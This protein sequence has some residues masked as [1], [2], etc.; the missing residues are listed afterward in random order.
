[1]SKDFAL[2]SDLGQVLNEV[3]G[4]EIHSFGFCTNRE[5]CLV[6]FW[7]LLEMLKRTLAMSNQMKAFM[8]L[9]K[10]LS[11]LNIWEYH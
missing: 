3:S 7:L 5:I 4:L 8:L 1:M 10:V 9:E 2:A 11:W 6:L